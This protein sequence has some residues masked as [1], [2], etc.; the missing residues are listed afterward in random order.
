MIGV[1]IFLFIG[2]VVFIIG[3]V[4][5][6]KG[7]N[8]NT[9]KPIVGRINEVK[10]GARYD[11]DSNGSGMS[12]QCLVEYE[13][14]SLKGN[15][16]LKGNKIAVGYMSTNS[17]KGHKAIQQKLQSSNQVQL[18]VNPQDESQSVICKGTNRFAHVLMTFGVMI[19]LFAIGMMP[20]TKKK[21]SPS[22]KI[23][24]VEIIEY[25]TVK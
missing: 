1:A 22:G 23:F 25:K 9:W 10:F 16:I 12:Y 18:W 19:M 24:Q 20:L 7:K 8:T 2:F 5:F 3:L 21:K 4:L 15:G 13:Y 14:D 17:K 6:F 11:N